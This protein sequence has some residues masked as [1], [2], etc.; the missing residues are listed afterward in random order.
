[1]V[2][3][4]RTEAGYEMTEVMGLWLVPSGYWLLP[5]SSPLFI[6]ARSSLGT[7]LFLF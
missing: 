4:N 2:I 3:M 7:S 5:F 6:G 1:V